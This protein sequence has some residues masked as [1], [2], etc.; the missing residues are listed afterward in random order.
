MEALAT[1]AQ[2]YVTLLVS[3]VALL[4][5]HVFLQGI[6][7]TFELGAAWNAG[8]RDGAKKAEGVLVG[9]AERCSANFRETY[10]GFL[11]LTA[12]AMVA[13]S[14]SLALTGGWIW[15]VARIV[16][17]PLYLA[18]V[19]YIRSIVWLISVAGLATIAVSLVG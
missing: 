13:S 10:P 11:A 7:A 3:S 14:S 9:R 2:P 5:V 8:P 4:F 18:G 19:P 17:V 15:F 12:A 6:L 1:Q 16:Y